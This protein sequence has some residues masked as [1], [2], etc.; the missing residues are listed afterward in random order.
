MSEITNS[1][2]SCIQSY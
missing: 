2:H 1:L